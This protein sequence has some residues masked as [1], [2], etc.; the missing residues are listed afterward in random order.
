MMLLSQ[1]KREEKGNKRGGRLSG[2]RARNQTPTPSLSLTHAL[3]HSR[4]SLYLALSLTGVRPPG[5][6]A[7]QHASPARERD[8]RFP[9]HASQPPSPPPIRVHFTQ[10]YTHASPS[11]NRPSTCR[12]P[13]TYLYPSL[14]YKLEP[15]IE[16]QS[17]TS[18]TNSGPRVSVK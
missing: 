14:L 4:V 7:G 3:S 15:R 6:A 8:E 5:T 9:T 11:Q 1:K 2:L 13:T 18:V 17:A 10:P 12:K 16:P